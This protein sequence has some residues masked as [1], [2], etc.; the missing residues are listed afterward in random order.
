MV[1]FCHGLNGIKI[2]L[3]GSWLVCT[4]S[5][6]ISIKFILI[7]FLALFVLMDEFHE[8]IKV[9][10]GMKE[11]LEE[12]R[13]I[14]KEIEKIKNEI[15]DLQEKE[16]EIKSQPDRIE[17]YRRRLTKLQEEIER[18]NAITKQ[19][20]KPEDILSLSKILSQ[21]QL[22]SKVLEYFSTLYKE[23]TSV[24]TI[25][26]VKVRVNSIEISLV[27]N[28]FLRVVR[29]VLPQQVNIHVR[30]ISKLVAD[31]I[32]LYSKTIS[33]IYDDKIFIAT[34]G[35]NKKTEL[36]DI[37][38]QEKI[39]ER[40]L[41]EKKDLKKLYENISKLEIYE[42]ILMEVKARITEDLLKISLKQ[43]DRYNSEVFFGTIY[44][45]ENTDKWMCD[46][47][48]Q[49]IGG[50]EEEA[51]I[52]TQ[53]QREIFSTK[54]EKTLIN[55]LSK[56]MKKTNTGKIS[57]EFYKIIRIIK[58]ASY[59]ERSKDKKIQK[60][61]SEKIEEHFKNRAGKTDKEK[62][63]NRA[64]K[65]A[66]SQVMLSITDELAYE[67]TEKETEL[68]HFLDIFKN[69]EE[70]VVDIA[71]NSFEEMIR[72]SKVDS[73]NYVAR[74]AVERIEEMA[75]NFTEVTEGVFTGSLLSHINIEFYNR[76]LHN[77]FSTISSDL[78]DLPIEE[79]KDILH[80]I[81]NITKQY[82]DSLSYYLSIEAIYQI[83][84]YDG[85]AT[86][87]IRQINDLK[88]LLP[89]D[90]IHELVAYSFKDVRLSR[91]ILN[92]LEKQQKTE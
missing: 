64:L 83:V 76:I 47:L 61:I 7:F 88:V 80:L 77:V 5:S 25:G 44:H 52:S 73:I 8:S 10:E 86:E 1:V 63:R 23:T 79:W 68:V 43:L 35:V 69:S 82:K 45:I 32:L 33:T 60:V 9:A 92:S 53:E 18:Q 70:Y 17:S 84:S 72:E 51:E 27:Y 20:E 58:Q 40:I 3:V 54:E 24:I 49:K 50:T 11:E 14:Q 19:I 91:N 29:K 78:E 67:E 30:T 89:N 28:E 16:K 31:Y 22:V 13:R 75:S 36:P 12:V 66:D 71:N 65:L 62:I 4:V 55:I 87:F 21:K 41:K 15:L 37:E 6:G 2:F 46:N 39:L 57:K 26:Q 59:T 42:E 81:L 85:T 38:I 48:V 74:G 56:S 90:L 34:Y